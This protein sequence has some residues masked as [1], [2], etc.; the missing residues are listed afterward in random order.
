MPESTPQANL[1]AAERALIAAVLAFAAERPP[2]EMRAL[3]KRIEELLGS[4][5]PGAVLRLLQRLG[6][7]GAEFSYYPPDPLARKIHS[8]VGD[9]VLKDEHALSGAERL[10]GL[11]TLPV[12]FLQNHLS[13]SDAN[14]F[15]VLLDRAGLGSF[16]DRLTVIAGP[17]VYSDP[18]RRFSSLCFGTIKTPQS[19]DLA[20]EEAVMSVR[21]V[22]RLARETIALATG[23][24]K[25][26]DA[27]LVFVEGT[28]SRSG[29]MQR[30]LPAVTRY[31]D[32][33]D[34]RL[35]PV[36]ITGTEQLVPLDDER[37]HSASVRVKIGTPATAGTLA[38]RAEGNR[39]LMMDAVGVAIG[40]LLPPEYRGAY[41]DSEPGLDEARNVA[42]DV[43]GSA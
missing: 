6:T 14:A 5:E 24:Q 42:T 20:S 27:L 18:M 23:R 13:Y 43:F 22:A 29:G 1:D 39:R 26:G 9:V 30:A 16:A 21:E 32:A 15:S 35:V 40:R 11:E 17:K 3:E 19:S 37:L 7:T 25:A 34:A 33:A 8:A 31:L 12:V 36:G 10:A 2:E 38:E 28:R 4:A 41:A